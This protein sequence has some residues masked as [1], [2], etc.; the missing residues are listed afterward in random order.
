MTTVIS[1]RFLPASTKVFRYS[2]P[3]GLEGDLVSKV[4]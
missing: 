3:S 2:S 1:R 4:K